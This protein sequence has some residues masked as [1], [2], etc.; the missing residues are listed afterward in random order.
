MSSEL[1]ILITLVRR[2]DMDLLQYVHCL[3]V[4]TKFGQ[5]YMYWREDDIAKVYAELFDFDEEV[6]ILKVETINGVK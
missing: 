6:E 2:E 1:W 5:N 3:N 4:D